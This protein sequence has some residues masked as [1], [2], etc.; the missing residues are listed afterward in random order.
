MANTIYTATGCA[1]CKITKKYMDERSIPCEEFDIKGDGKEAFGQFY[2]THRADVFRG[3]EGIE[4]PV[5]TDGAHI[6]QGVGVILAYLRAGTR[7]DAVI[8]RSDLSHGWMDGI[9]VSES[10]GDPS[11]VDE[12]IATLSFIRKHGLK[13]QVDTYGPNAAFLRLLLEN[14]LVD[15]TVMEIKAPL[16]LY[17]LVLGREIEPAE[18]QETIRLVAKSPEYRFQTTI[19]PLI[20]EGSGKRL[21]TPEEISDIAKTILECTGSNREPYLLRSLGTPGDLFKYR[22]AARKH[23]VAAEIDRGS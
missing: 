21:L 22:S 15:R 11:L 23:Q 4:F 10:E 18:V 8:G 13:L 2:R 6:R 1:R 16:N 5:F 14:G 20:P 17:S 12:V 7:L 3:K 9:H 19:D